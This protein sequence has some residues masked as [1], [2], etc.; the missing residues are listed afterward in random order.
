[1]KPRVDLILA[2]CLMLLVGAAAPDKVSDWKNLNG[3][4]KIVVVGA[5]GEKVPTDSIEECFFAF[6]EG[7]YVQKTK[8]KILEE[9]AVKIDPNKTPKEMDLIATTEGELKGKV[10]R[11]IYEVTKDCLKLTFA[12]PD[13][14]RPTKFDAAKGSN[15]GYMELKKLE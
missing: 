2:S 5:D 3:S 14:D 12:M 4:W 13:K 8:E 9:G 11:L 1:M 6:S 10:Q 7:T 15:H